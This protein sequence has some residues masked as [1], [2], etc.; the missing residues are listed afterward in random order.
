MTELTR[1][2]ASRKFLLAVAAF[3]GFL[4]TRNYKEAVAVVMTYIGAET[5]IDGRAA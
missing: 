5:Y 3:V 1:K 4:A 2:L